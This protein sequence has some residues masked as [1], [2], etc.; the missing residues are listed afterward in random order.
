MYLNQLN[1]RQKESFL[2]L[3]SRLTMA[4]GEDSSDEEAAIER[5]RE[6]M[7]F[8]GTVDVTRV[9]GDI[10]VTAFDTHKV[11]VI[12]A[13]EL[14]RLAYADDYMHEA[15]VSMVREVCA[16]MG[17][18]EDWLTTMGEWATRFNQ[19]EELEGEMAEYRDA[20][21]S[22]DLQMMDM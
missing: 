18:S 19:V 10:D 3:A 11:R 9:L 1:E 6:E 4:D 14:L 7:N 15:E 8:D 13:L 5:V 12:A 16:A 22:Y 17:F 21:L 2:I 20:L